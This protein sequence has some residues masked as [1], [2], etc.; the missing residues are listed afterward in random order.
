LLLE[1]VTGIFW[2]VGLYLLVDFIAGFFHWAEDTLGTPETPIW[3]QTFVAPNVLHHNAPLE[4]NKI[5]W[6]RN[7]LPIYLICI[8]VLGVAWLTDSLG[9]KVWFFAFVGLFAQQTHRWS[10]TPRK[11]LP[12]LVVFLQRLK[13]LQD[14]KHHYKHHRADH[15]TH[16]CVGTPWL[17]PILDRFGVW[18]FLERMLVPVFGAPR[19]P[20][21]DDKTWYND[22]A[23]YSRPISQ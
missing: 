6:F 11:A 15:S 19:R 22:R 5:H 13:I 9:W 8:A 21:L 2:A 3:G 23:F 10:H 17:N 14:A 20:D 1:I 18:K 12:R 7:S 4:M 16:F